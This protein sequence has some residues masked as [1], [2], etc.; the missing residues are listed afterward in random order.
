[1]A[2][3]ETEQDWTIRWGEVK[4]RGPLGEWDGWTWGGWEG[5]DRWWAAVK[6]APPVGSLD[7]LERF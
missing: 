3:G 2:E 1:M 4:I 6:A 7:F 5:T